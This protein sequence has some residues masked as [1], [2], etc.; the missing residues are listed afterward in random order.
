[1]VAI[2]EI[3]KSS[4]KSHI[5]ISANSNT[6]CDEITDRL[7]QIFGKNDI[8][9]MYAKSY[10]EKNVK[11]SIM[12]CSN[13][14]NGEFRI[15]C[16]KYIYG[17]RIIIC[18][19]LTAGCISR[20]RHDADF[21]PGHFTHIIIDECASSNETATMIPIAGKYH[22]FLSRFLF[23][24]LFILAQI[25]AYLHAWIHGDPSIS[26]NQNPKQNPR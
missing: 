19:L 15:P 20:A 18:T 13:F 14:S 5:L 11:S 26:D 2:E 24:F 25:L 21:D 4:K 1:M 10:N 12:K 16:L 7:L 23:K 17:F 3:I 22:R 8:L 6:A 9:R